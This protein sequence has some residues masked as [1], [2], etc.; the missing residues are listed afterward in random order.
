MAGGQM[1]IGT[2]C[3]SDEQG[4]RLALAL[5]QDAAQAGEVPVGAVLVKDGRV[6]AEGRNAPIAL[7]D[8]TAHAEIA[9]LRSA[10]QILGNYR[11]DD[12]T[13]YVTLEPCPMCAGAMLHA[14][15]PRVV[16][17]AADTK[18]GAAGSVVDLFAEPLLNHQTLI[19]GGVLAD[20]CGLALSEFFRQRRSEQK[21]E[22]RLAHP[23]RE[24]ALRTPDKAFAG[25]THYPWQP[26]YVSDLPA[27][28]GLR[29]HFIDEGPGDAARTWLLLHGLPSWSHE[30]RHMIPAL[31]A[32]G[33]RVVAIDLPGFG[34][35]DKPK[36]ESA[37]SERWHVRVVQ[38]LI[39]RL[40]LQSLVLVTHGLNGLVGL[41]VPLAAP[42]RFV[43]LLAINAWLPEPSLEAPK[44]LRTW[45]E[46]IA[47]KPRLAIGEQMARAD[48][49]VAGSEWIACDA[50]FP[51]GGYRAAL[52]A[53]ADLAL[54]PQNTARAREVLDFWRDEWQGRSLV[55]SG[56][57]DLLV[58]HG[59]AQRLRQRIRGTGDIA[60]IPDLGHFISQHGASVALRAMEYFTPF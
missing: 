5:A 24:D 27:L 52:R 36:K 25:L 42:E 48:R 37:H 41:G 34:R 26:H 11:L 57:K 31:L 19:Q 9:A 38:E 40:D 7:H 23:L 46:H 56:G 3:E 32:A 50:P 14:R 28:E 43:G 2:V 33:D 18:T 17:G 22:R 1:L 54:E 44:V 45:T 35:S 59:A 6:I 13:L 51:D 60:V 8:P 55:I 29:L 58:D 16:F 49:A 21:E 39:E 4:M 10:A 15:L 47:R 20:E 53:F 12:C 30:F